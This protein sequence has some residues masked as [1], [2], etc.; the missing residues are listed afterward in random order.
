VAA[1]WQYDCLDTIPAQKRQA[2]GHGIVG[3]RSSNLLGSTTSARTAKESARQPWR[4]F[5]FRELGFA[6][7]ARVPVPDALDLARSFLN[8]P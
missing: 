7:P 4:V 6:D 2:S 1:N 8:F 3:V 5:S